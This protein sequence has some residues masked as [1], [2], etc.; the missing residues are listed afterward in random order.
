[1]THDEVTLKRYGDKYK[2]T[3][4]I[5]GSRYPDTDIVPAASYDTKLD[6]SISRTR[7]RVFEL[8]LCNAWEYFVTLTLSPAK[9]DRMNLPAFR[10]DLSQWIRN[11]RRLHHIDFCYLLIPEMHQDG[12]WHMHGLVSGLRADAFEFNA[13][14]FLDYPPYRDKFGYISLSH[15]R[16]HERV[17]RYITKYISKDFAARAADLGAHLYY[18]SRGLAGAELLDRGFLHL[19]DSFKSDYQND[20]VKIFW[21]DSPI[22]LEHPFDNT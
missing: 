12:A 3:Y 17:A 11:Q 1:M 9:Y 22:Q 4:F 16:S 13:Q 7:S 20:F 15:V 5:T 6:N 14:G 2:L 8:A 21:L 18:A 19:P 10:R